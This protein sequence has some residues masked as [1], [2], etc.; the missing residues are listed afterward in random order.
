MIPAEHVF[1]LIDGKGLLSRHVGGLLGIIPRLPPGGVQ[2]VYAVLRDIDVILAIRMGGFTPMRGHIDGLGVILVGRTLI[3]GRSDPLPIFGVVIG[4]EGGLL[5]TN[6][7]RG[8]REEVSLEIHRLPR[9]K[10]H[11][12][13]SQILG[14]QGRIVPYKLT[15]GLQ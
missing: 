6:L 11:V 2:A 1:L 8:D 7:L 14:L 3:E 15:V 5:G 13:E 10:I 4:D 12:F 9:L